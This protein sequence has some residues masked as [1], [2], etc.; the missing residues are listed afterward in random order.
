MASSARGWK[1]T[2]DG[3]DHTD[4]RMQQII[5]FR[6]GRPHKEIADEFGISEPRVSRIRRRLQLPDKRYG[7]STQAAAASS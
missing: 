4:P 6:A 5:F 7:K 1:K 2:P 3:W